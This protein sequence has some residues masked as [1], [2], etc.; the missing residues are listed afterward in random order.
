MKKQLVIHD[1]SSVSTESS[2]E[3]KSEPTYVTDMKDEPI[4]YGSNFL[5]RHFNN[6]KRGSSSADDKQKVVES[7]TKFKFRDGNT[8]QAIKE[9]K[10][11]VQIGN[12]EVDIHINNELPLLLSKDAM[13]K[14]EA[15]IDFMKDSINMLRQKMDIKF[16]SS[17]HYL[18]PISK[19]YEALNEL[20]EN[21]TKSILLSIE[22]VSNRKLRAKHK[23]CRKITQT[24]WPQ[25]F[26]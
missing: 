12:K 24:V 16:S 22:N 25:Q 9:V 8:L 19:S 20:D 18:I 6:Y 5:R 4:C 14:A 21:N 3:I 26:E 17:G 23:Y 13:K 11:P 1:S 7:S 10:I 2:F 15:T